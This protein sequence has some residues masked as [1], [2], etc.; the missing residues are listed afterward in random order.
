MPADIGTSN[1]GFTPADT[2]SCQ[3]WKCPVNFTTFG[4]PVQA[5]ARRSA[6]WVASVPDMVKRTSSAEGTSRVI[7][8]A[9]STSSS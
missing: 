8:S 9:H 5:R 7:H 6:R 4:R 3:P 2:P 1:G